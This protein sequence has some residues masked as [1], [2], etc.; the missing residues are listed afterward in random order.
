MVL[1]KALIAACPKWGS[2]IACAI[3]FVLRGFT[4]HCSKLPCQATWN[5]LPDV[6][7]NIIAKCPK[8]EAKIFWYS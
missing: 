8:W 4:T 1:E 7:K 5:R 2:Q 6:H 3:G